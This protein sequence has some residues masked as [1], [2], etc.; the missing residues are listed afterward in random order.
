MHDTYINSVVFTSVLYI[1]SGGM[2]W[3]GIP[4]KFRSASRIPTPKK[5]VKV[6]DQKF[7][8]WDMGD[9][10][11]R[12]FEDCIL[13]YFS[14]H[15]LLIPI[16]EFT[17]FWLIA[18]R[19]KWVKIIGRFLSILA[20]VMDLVPVKEENEITAD[21]DTEEYIQAPGVA[22]NEE[23]IAAIEKEIAELKEQ[24]VRNNIRMKDLQDQRDEE[25]RIISVIKDRCNARARARVERLAEHP[26]EQ[27]A[28]QPSVSAR[29]PIVDDDEEEEEYETFEEARS[30]EDETS[31]D[32]DTIIG[33]FEPE[34]YNLAPTS[35]LKTT[36]FT[37]LKHVTFEEQEEAGGLVEEP[38]Q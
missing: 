3:Y 14:S 27:P 9:L 13:A 33:T 4:S 30:Y 26:A 36:G 38:L 1:V 35:I 29:R 34:E 25:E 22:E 6:P 15:G 17:V 18:R 2:F 28:E 21:G 31:S 10:E 5:V 20:V 7:S 19:I 8:V 32:H 37:A 11:N 23:E 24:L 12:S 16:L